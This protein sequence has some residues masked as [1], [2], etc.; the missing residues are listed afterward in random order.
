MSRRLPA[1][2]W[3]DRSQV[4]QGDPLAVPRIVPESSQDLAV[5]GAV[6]WRLARD[7]VIEGAD[8][9]SVDLAAPAA[10]R[11]VVV[12]AVGGEDQVDVQWPV[13]ELDEGPAVTDVGLLLGTDL[14]PEFA[15]RPG[16]PGAVE[17]RALFD[18]QVDILRGVRVPLQD[19]SGLADDQVLDLVLF[20]HVAQTL[21]ALQA[22]RSLDPTS[23]GP[24]GTRTPRWPGRPA[25][26]LRKRRQ[27]QSARCGRRRPGA[28][29]A[30]RPGSRLGPSGSLSPMSSR[31]KSN[32]IRARICGLRSGRWLRASGGSVAHRAAMHAC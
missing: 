16:Q 23:S 28:R 8:P 25:A 31:A 2:A 30:G 11:F 18:E 10:D 29:R 4:R 5:L 9:V 1:R 26:R 27:H 24:T 22:N 32:T 20:E 17:E 6:C 14:E 3:R 19:R 21:E 7:H 12:D 13:P 15:Q